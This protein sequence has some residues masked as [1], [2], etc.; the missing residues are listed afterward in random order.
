MTGD[1]P[2]KA[3]KGVKGCH[4]CFVNKFD[5]LDLKNKL[6]ETTPYKTDRRDNN[7]ATINQIEAVAIFPQRK[8]KAQMA[9]L[10]NSYNY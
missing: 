8:L 10:V 9:C 7:L 4:E 1:T 2:L 6:P 3:L 5:N